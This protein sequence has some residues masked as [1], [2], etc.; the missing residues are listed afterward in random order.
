MIKEYI[1]Y[2]RD[3]PK[4][5]WFKRKLFGWGWTPVTWQ[6]WLLVAVYLTVVL[7]LSSKI[8]AQSSVIDTVYYLWL[9]IIFFTFIFI[10][11][12][13]KKGEKPKWNWGLPKTQEPK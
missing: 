2:L 9:P 13:I 4:H 8:N 12:A 6:G 11:I 10:V 3:N 1:N 7:F 5:L